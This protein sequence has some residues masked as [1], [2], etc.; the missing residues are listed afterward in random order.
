MTQ[1]SQSI[2]DQSDSD[3]DLHRPMP[4]VIKLTAKETFEYLQK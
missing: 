3:A 4:L 2:T 1:P